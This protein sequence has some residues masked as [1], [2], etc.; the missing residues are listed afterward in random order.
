MTSALETSLRALYAKKGAQ[1]PYQQRAWEA[2]A[3]RPFWAVKTAAFR[4]LLLERL[5]K[6]H[7]SEESFVVP[8]E[9]VDPTPFL[10]PE[11]ARSFLLFVN[12]QFAPHLSQIPEGVV[13]MS[14][15]EAKK[16]PYR[17]FLAKREQEQDTSE[18][19]PFIHLNAAL[20]QE[21]LFLY[22]PPGL[23]LKAPLQLL[24]LTQGEKPFQAM[25]PHMVVSVG[26]KS[27]ATLVLKTADLQ[28]AA[29]WTNSALH[30]TVAE[31]ARLSLIEE[32][33]DPSAGWDFLAV[34]AKIK[35]SGT[36]AFFRCAFGLDE[37]SYRDISM[38]LLGEEAVGEV[39]SIAWLRK[40]ETAHLNVE[41][42]HEAPSTRS[43]QWIKCVAAERAR[44]GFSGKIFVAQEAQQTDAYQLNNNL[45]LGERATAYS[46]PN[47]EVFADDVKAS[48][49]ATCSRPDAE[50]LFYLQA[51]GVDRSLAEKMLV[52]A[53]C[54]DLLEELTIA[55]LRE[56]CEKA[57]EREYSEEG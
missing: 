34:R 12:G 7:V 21:G 33:T 41:M 28:Q 51:R 6:Q 36:C 17:A 56:Q 48:H 29:V 10:L 52:R 54:R 47:L 8:A 19:N 53:F 49:G 9:K 18:P 50:E 11:T 55:S 20:F 13:A 44:S 57:L 39:K 2:F 46:Q 40:K 30:L 37:F 35:Q 1:D 24:F 16:G 32:Q 45:I 15:E 27:R 22:V 38:R 14:L 26:R 42:R 43:N 3:A 4:Y 25:F 31:E 23:E 5:K